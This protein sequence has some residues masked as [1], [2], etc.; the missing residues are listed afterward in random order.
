MH[1]TIEFWT[2]L[3]C[4]HQGRDEVKYEFSLVKYRKY[5]CK[6][7]DGCCF[8]IGGSSNQTSKVEMVVYGSGG[9]EDVHVKAECQVHNDTNIF[10]MIGVYY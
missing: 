9:N 4:R 7:N 5:V 3:K 2:V 10:D 8:S 6:G 1:L